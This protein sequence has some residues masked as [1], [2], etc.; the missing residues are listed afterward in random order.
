MFR[1]LFGPKYSYRVKSINIHPV[2]LLMDKD[3]KTKLRTTFLGNESK[4]LS[5]NYNFACF[6]SWDF[7][8]DISTFQNLNTQQMTPYFKGLVKRII[9]VDT[10]TFYLKPV[11]SAGS[12]KFSKSKG[13]LL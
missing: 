10:R 6:P 7:L 13:P 3:R 1:S 5:H 9:T 4:I 12:F 8:E 11:Q 2:Q